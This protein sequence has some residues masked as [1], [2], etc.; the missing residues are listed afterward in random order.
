[1]KGSWTKK[2]QGME[3]F[4]WSVS[5]MVDGEGGETRHDD[6]KYMFYDKYSRASADLTPNCT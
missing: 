3:W 1:M 2:I 5:W 4:P 6:S